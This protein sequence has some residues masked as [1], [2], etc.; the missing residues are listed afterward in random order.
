MWKAI[1]LVIIALGLLGAVVWSGGRSERADFTFINRGDVNT[2]DLQRMSYLQDLRVGRL[3]FEGLVQNDVFSEDFRVVPAVAESWEISDG[4]TEYTFTIREDAKWSNGSPVRASDFVYSWR[5]AM[6][7]DTAADYYKLF[8]LIEGV[9][10]FYDWR[11]AELSAIATGTSTYDSGADLWQATEAKFADTVK[12]EARDDRT[13]WMR[14]VRPTP[15]WLDICAFAVFYPVYPPLLAQYERI[16][17]GTG[18]VDSQRGWTKAGTLISN[19]PFVLTDWKFKRRMWFEQ[20]PH[21]WNQDSLAIRTIEIP[22][23]E[24]SNAQV[25]AFQPGAVDWVSDVTAAYRA[26]IYAQ[27]QAFYDEHRDEY[28]RLLA[29]GWDAVEIDR[30]LPR[31]PRNMLQVWPVFGTYFYN[32][33][34]LPTLPDGREN[35]F[36]DRRI[37][38]AFAMTIDKKS[39]TDEVRRIGEPVARTLIPPDSIGG[40]TSPDGMV[41]IGA[42]AGDAE[43]AAIA[44]EARALIEDAG[45]ADRMPIIEILFNKDAGHDLIAQAVAKN[46]ERYLGIEVRLV[47][48]EVKVY[49]DDLKNRNYM[50][51]RA[52]WYGDY[53]DP[54]TFLGINKTGDGNNDR[55]YSNPA[56]D[57][58]LLDAGN[59]RDPVKRMQILTE[60]ERILIEEDFPLVPI[61]HYSSVYLSDPFRM[62]GISTHARSKQNLYLTDILTDGIGPDEPKRMP[63]KPRSAEGRSL[64]AP[65]PSEGSVQ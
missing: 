3:L 10:E 28:D 49:R 4:G 54:T 51:A 11:T 63:M 16:N 15:Y 50:V 25:L 27:K 46:W 43:R 60:A 55:A 47:T 6:L 41:H 12:L 23:M 31:D 65:T 18:R 17:P 29:E 37:R 30:R 24:D 9:Q 62:S 13:L 34:C 61:F 48:K 59:E 44:A 21:W 56:Y 32:F 42:V 7:P 35:P 20:N 5:R 38:R 40:Y 26:E 33:N 52:G 53:G 22:S 14:L 58:L 8:A 2:L 36:A 39:V 1:T 19:G 45:W 57:Q 64:T